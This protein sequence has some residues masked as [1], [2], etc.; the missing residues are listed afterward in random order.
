MDLSLHCIE[1]HTIYKYKR[2]CNGTI[3]S[4]HKCHYLFIHL[5]MF[6][7]MLQHNACFCN[8]S[9]HQQV[10]VSL[11]VLHQRMFI[12]RE[13]SQTLGTDRQGLLEACLP[14]II[15]HIIPLT[16]AS[17]NE[18]LAQDRSV[19]RHIKSAVA[20]Y[21]MIFEELGQ[22]VKNCYPGSLLYVVCFYLLLI[23]S[24]LLYCG[25]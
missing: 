17:K 11:L 25:T 19:Q 8:Y 13:L 1:R 15:T 20:C 6:H 24:R 23:N 21:D 10:I 12:V 18:E 4:G 22:K 5:E 9:E 2:F 16:A 7:N 3:L 14:Q